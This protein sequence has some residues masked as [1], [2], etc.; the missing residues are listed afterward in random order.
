M[1]LLCTLDHFYVLGVE[2][3]GFI[4]SLDISRGKLIFLLTSTK[5]VELE[6]ILIFIAE[7]NI[8]ICQFVANI[9]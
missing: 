1:N 2:K 5:V 9:D 7:E 8:F 4:L 3:L 6:A